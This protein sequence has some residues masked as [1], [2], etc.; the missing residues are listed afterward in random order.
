MRLKGAS[1]DQERRQENGTCRDQ[2]SAG[3]SFLDKDR[4]RRRCQRS[5]SRDSRGKTDPRRDCFDRAAAPRQVKETLK[6]AVVILHSF[7]SFSCSYS[8]LS[9]R[10][11]RK[12]RIRTMPEFHPVRTLTSVGDFSFKSSSVIS[13]LFVGERLANNFS[14][15]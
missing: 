8:A 7:L 4:V 12:A 9:L 13:I 6:P 3:Q 15:I 2:A 11:A 1:A 5:A 14:R 10:W